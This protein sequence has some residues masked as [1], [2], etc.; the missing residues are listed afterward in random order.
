[1]DCLQT[2]VARRIART[3]DDGDALLN[4]EV[5]AL[6]RK[7]SPRQHVVF[8]LVQAPSLL[9]M[10]VHAVDDYKWG[11]LVRRDDWI[12]G[13]R[14]TLVMRGRSRASRSGGISVL[15]AS[16][17]LYATSLAWFGGRLTCH[18]AETEGVLDQGA[19]IHAKALPAVS[20]AIRPSGHCGNGMR[21]HWVVPGGPDD[22]PPIF[23]AQSPILCARL[24]LEASTKISRSLDFSRFL[25][26]AAAISTTHQI[27]CIFAGHSSRFF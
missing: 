2:Q 5:W 17:C 1:M 27:A 26:C 3:S 21:R 4:L 14:T 8:C 19:S 22:K 25:L 24:L 10:V 11:L 13:C 6:M 9:R 16:R 15:R 7:Y 18:W 12:E 23:V 20:Y